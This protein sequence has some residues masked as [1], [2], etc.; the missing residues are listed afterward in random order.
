MDSFVANWTSKIRSAEDFRPI[1]PSS[2]AD[3]IVDRWPVCIKRHRTQMPSNHGDVDASHLCALLTRAFLHPDPSPV[4]GHSQ[5]LV[6]TAARAHAP[7]AGLCGIPLSDRAELHPG[8]CHRRLAPRH[9]LHGVGLLPS[10]KSAS[11]RDSGSPKR[12]AHPGAPQR[13]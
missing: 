3:I 7:D 11:T 9:I 8:P 12:L 5:R 2:I 10:A 13:C 4:H 6:I 1:E